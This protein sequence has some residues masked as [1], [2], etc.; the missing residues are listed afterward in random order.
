[1][2]GVQVLVLLAF[3]ASTF[4]AVAH[5]KAVEPK[6]IFEDFIMDLINQFLSELTDPMPLN[7]TS[8]ELFIEN[9]IVL[10]ADTAG[11]SL[12]GTASI[13]V[14][15]VSVGLLGNFVIKVNIGGI[16]ATGSVLH[17]IN[18]ETVWQE[19]P[20]HGEGPLEAHLLDINLEASGTLILLPTVG[21]NNF[22]YKL[23]V[24]GVSLAQDGLMGGPSHPDHQ[25]VS[26]HLNQNGVS[27]IHALESQLHDFIR[28]AI[29]EAINGPS[30]ILM[31]MKH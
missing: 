27:I 10:T 22:D 16:V 2:K 28:D 3:F 5:N 14:T 17:H 23:T 15:S 8:I 19:G 29:D 26:D 21:V 24:G 18:S 7:D 25:R 1:M 9:I 12:A 4:A 11:I 20:I 30:K 31:R 13:E 6:N